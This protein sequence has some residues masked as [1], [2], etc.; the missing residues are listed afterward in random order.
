MNGVAVDVTCPLCG[1]AV[2]WQAGGTSN[3]ARTQAVIRCAAHPGVHRFRIEV[4][5]IDINKETREVEYA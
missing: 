2:E 1:A 4:R 5:L 3:G